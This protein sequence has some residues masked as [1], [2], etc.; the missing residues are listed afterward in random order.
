MLL[1]WRR[2]WLPLLDDPDG[3]DLGWGGALARAS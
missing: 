3:Q 1:G 2:Q